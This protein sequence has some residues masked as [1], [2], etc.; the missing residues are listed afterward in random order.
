VLIIDP[1]RELGAAGPDGDFAARRT[2]HRLA[3]DVLSVRH[4]LQ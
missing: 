3:A 4:L 2:A 1:D